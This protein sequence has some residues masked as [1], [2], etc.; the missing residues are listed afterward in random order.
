M[1]S[2]LIAAP[3]R[4][5]LHQI[6]GEGHVLLRR[7]QP[8]ER[9]VED[10]Y[11]T[12]FR[13][14]ARHQVCKFEGPQHL[15]QGGFSMMQLSGPKLAGHA[16]APVLDGWNGL[17]QR[18][19][20]ERAPRSKFKEW[21]LLTVTEQAAVERDVEEL[22][23][24][25]MTAALHPEQ[26]LELLPPEQDGALLANF[27]R[28]AYYNDSR[29]KAAATAILGCVRQYETDLIKFAVKPDLPPTF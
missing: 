29:V 9:G 17:V 26:P 16:L 20:K 3:K 21:S 7:M 15:A 1:A 13:R 2:P 28:R 12:T 11:L 4:P 8:T 18:L 10:K 25:A 23:E 19:A 5:W 24:P 6:R 27:W 14:I 22:L